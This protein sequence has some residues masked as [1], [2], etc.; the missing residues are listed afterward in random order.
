MTTAT[1]ETTEERQRIR[2]EDLP[3]LLRLIKGADSVEL[4][5]SIASENQRATITGLPL[6]PVEAQPRQIFFFDT[7]DLDLNKAG[8]VVRA[9]RIQGGRGDTVVKLRPVDPAH[10]PP[11]VRKSGSVNV[12]V[13]VIPGGFVCSAAMKGKTTGDQIRDA[14]QGG[15]PLRKLFTR[16]QREFYASRA[17]TGID[18]DSLVTLGPTFVLKAQFTPRELNRRVVAELWFYPD[19]SRILELSTKSLP[20]EA[21]SVAVETRAYLTSHGITIGGVQQTKTR[22]ALDFF[23]GELRQETGRTKASARAAAASG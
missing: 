19:G 14:V 11:E 3:E 2:E 13:D 10:L 1:N 9:R 22:A 8:V 17:P 4:K 23:T 6:D 16:E 15:S 20:D 12:E 18:L 21:F 5:V 7:P